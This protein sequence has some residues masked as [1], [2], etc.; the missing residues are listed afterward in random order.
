VEYLEKSFDMA[1]S[2]GR[3]SFFVATTF[4]SILLYSKEVAGTARKQV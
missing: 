2:E 4:S 3:I 1:G